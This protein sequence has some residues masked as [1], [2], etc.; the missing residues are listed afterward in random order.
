MAV[1]LRIP[2][3]TRNFTGVPDRRTAGDTVL[4]VFRG[5]A[6]P[7]PTVRRRPREANETL[8]RQFVCLF[9]CQYIFGAL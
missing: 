7:L 9:V 8:E 5:V 3:G 2:Q 4:L 1:D 6:N